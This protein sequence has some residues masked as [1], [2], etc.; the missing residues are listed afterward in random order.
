MFNIIIIDVTATIIREKSMKKYVKNILKTTF[1]I[2]MM[3]VLNT[4]TSFACTRVLLDNKYGVNVGRNMDWHD[5]THAKYKL[6]VLP[7]GM[8]R[9]GEIATNPVKWKS[10]YGSLVMSMYDLLTVGGVNEKGFNVEVLYLPG[11]DYGVRDDKIPGM[12][13]MMLNQFLLDNF[14]SVSEAVEYLKINKIQQLT[15][16]LPGSDN[17]SGLHFALAD[18]TGNSAIIEYIN[19]KI[20]IYEGKEYK[21]LTNQPP[22]DQQLA[23]LKKYKGFGGDLVIP[24]GSTPSD[25]FVRASYNL[26][27]AMENSTETI[28]YAMLSG[29]MANAAQLHIKRAKSSDPLAGAESAPTSYTS[30]SDLTNMR[31]F[32][33]FLENHNYLYVNI[34]KFDFSEGQKEK[35]FNI[36]KSVNIIGDITDKF[37]ELEKP[38][39]FLDYNQYEKATPEQR[40]Q[41]LEQEDFMN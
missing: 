17:P 13:V 41:I 6:I 8:D 28:N 21:V 24:G 7:R 5:Q 15:I 31:Y 25:R 39:Q 30:I 32:V 9:T 16:T 40:V 3:V 20:V 11:S 22:Y 14:A 27:L 26:S 10:K 4:A 36:V 2:F 12:F 33:S 18:S 35:M 19:G 37:V 34:K 1:C 38:F 23:N 29:I